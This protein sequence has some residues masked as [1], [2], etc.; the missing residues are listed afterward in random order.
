LTL[1]N[2]KINRDNVYSMTESQL[3]IAQTQLDNILNNKENT[4]E[5]NNENL[6]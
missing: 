3:N 4:L 6:K 1:E 2:A 5:S